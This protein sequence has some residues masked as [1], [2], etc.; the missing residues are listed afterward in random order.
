[1]LKSMIACERRAFRATKKDSLIGAGVM[2]VGTL[3]FAAAG[4]AADRAGWQETSQVLL[5]LGSSAAFMLSTPVWLMK[6]QP[7]KA[8]TASPQ[9]GGA[10]ASSSALFMVIV[11]A[12]T[13]TV[14]APTLV[15]PSCL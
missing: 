7:W 4:I 12:L 14:Q 15:S 5:S 2:I 1:M 3:I 11:A 13:K 9:L 10:S 8:Q 6:G